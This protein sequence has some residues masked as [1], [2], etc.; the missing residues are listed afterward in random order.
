[1]TLLFF[2]QY[3]A[4]KWQAKKRIH[5][6]H[7]WKTVIISLCLSDYGLFL[8]SACKI[9][10]SV[11]NTHGCPAHRSG[12]LH[13]SHGWPAH[14]S[15]ELHNSHGCPAHRSGVLYNSHGCPAHR[16]GV[17][18]NNHPWLTYA[19]LHHLYIL[20]HFELDCY[21]PRNNNHICTQSAHISSM[22]NEADRSFNLFHDASKILSAMRSVGAI[23]ECVRAQ[24]R[25]FHV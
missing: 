12:V 3:L 24:A 22:G 14:R 8:M 10:T 16:S 20:P 18:Y 9:M 4:L 13:N 7:Y 19:A 15:G 25:E 21:R 23:L 11:Q 5:F 2:S 6:D 17:L 1:M